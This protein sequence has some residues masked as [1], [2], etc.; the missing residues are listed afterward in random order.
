MFPKT[1]YKQATTASNIKILSAVL[2]SLLLLPYNSWAEKL[3]TGNLTQIHILPH[4]IGIPI[5]KILLIKSNS[6]ICAVRFSSTDLGHDKKEPSIWS[7]GEESE[8]A[9]YDWYCLK[10]E[11]LNFS[12]G[13]VRSGHKKLS[14][15]APKGIGRFAFQ[16]GNTHIKCGSVKLLWTYPT[17]VYFPE[18]GGSQEEGMK[19][20]FAPTTYQNIDAV[21]LNKNHTWYGYDETRQR[22]FIDL[23]LLK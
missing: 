18:Y 11:P 6:E 4:G 10:G 3:Q 9:E 19:V 15:K 14:Y 20:L 1:M 8:Y 13:S 17:Y 16:T 7:S 5:G 12:E 22:K 2:F 21:D 23:E